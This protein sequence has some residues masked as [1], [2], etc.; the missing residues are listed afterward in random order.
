VT[1]TLVILAAGL[2]ARFGGDKQTAA[3]GP[4]GAMLLEYSIYDAMRAGFG[5]VVLV[6]RAGKER[7]MQAALSV[8]IGARVAVT[9]V[10]QRPDDLPPGCTAPPTRTKP[11][12]TAHAVLAARAA[13]QEPFAVANADDFY[14]RASFAALGEFLARAQPAESPAYA[15]VGFPLGATLSEAGPVNRALLRTDAEGWL[16]AIEERPGLTSAK[17]AAELIADTLVSMNLWGFTPA[18]FPA[19]EREF[20]IFLRAHGSS[21]DAEFLLPVAVRSLRASV[22]VLPARGSWC[23]VT[24]PADAPRVAAHLAELTERGEY[25]LDLWA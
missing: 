22:R 9:C 23:G 15:L 11:W 5:Q 8:R 20:V 24:Y 19:L 7:T 25:P 21:L 18:V 2:G 12:G 14:G 4:G 3:L 16:T 1:P 17:V 13:V 10:A 6:V